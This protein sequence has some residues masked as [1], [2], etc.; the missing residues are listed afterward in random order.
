VIFTNFSTLVEDLE[1]ITGDKSL[2]LVRFEEV[3]LRLK[4]CT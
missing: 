4:R 3:Y 2:E 1:E